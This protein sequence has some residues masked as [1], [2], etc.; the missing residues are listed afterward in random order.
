[1][2]DIAEVPSSAPLYRLSVLATALTRMWRGWRVIIPVVGVNA[3]VQSLL[4]LP[5]VLPYFRLPS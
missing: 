1:M 3:A 5:G 2:T 4:L